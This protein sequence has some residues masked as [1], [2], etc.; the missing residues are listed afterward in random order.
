MSPAESA[1]RERLLLAAVALIREHGL[2]GLT[3]PRVAKAAGVSQ[4]HLTYYFPTRNA[5]LTSVLM[6][7]AD[8]QL[9]GVEQALATGAADAKQLSETMGAAF[10][11]AENSRVLISFALA[12]S[13][14]RDARETF[15]RLTR[16]IRGGIATTADRVG[17]PDDPKTMA[18]VHSL[19]VGLSVLNLALGGSPLRPQPAECMAMLFKLLHQKKTTGR[20]RRR[21]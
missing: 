5:L 16:G 8:D 20:R 4:S 2:A 7:T 14:N 21:T 12:A 6:R 11:K 9:A 17:I 10:E 3:Q 1:V 19:A 13:E 18:L 15:E